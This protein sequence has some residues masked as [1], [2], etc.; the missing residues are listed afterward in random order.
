MIALAQIWIGTRWS[1]RQ[2]FCIFQS[3]FGGF[4]LHSTGSA[5]IPLFHSFI[6][7]VFFDFFFTFCRF[8]HK[9]QITRT[10]DLKNRFGPFGGCQKISLDRVKQSNSTGICPKKRLPNAL[11]Y[12]LPISSRSERISPVIFIHIQYV[13]KN[14]PLRGRFISKN[15]N[16]SI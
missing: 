14:R 10:L 15:E 11:L 9:R 8:F 3:A 6:P 4:F 7:L 1:E 16:L 5:H 13:K 12:F 2:D